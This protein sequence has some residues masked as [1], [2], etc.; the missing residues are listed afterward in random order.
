[1]TTLMITRSR[2]PIHLHMTMLTLLTM[3]MIISMKGSMPTVTIKIRGTNMSTMKNVVKPMQTLMSTATIMT[4][5]MH[6]TAKPT[7]THMT[8][9]FTRP[10]TTMGMLKEKHMSMT[11][12]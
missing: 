9:V 6:T 4:M 11:M 1:M 5:S 10:T 3:N 12:S 2:I 8:M 7:T